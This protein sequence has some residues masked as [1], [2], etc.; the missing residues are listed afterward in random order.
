M[1]ARKVVRRFIVVAAL[2]LCTAQGLAPAAA[3][4]SGGEAGDRSAVRVRKSVR[5]LSSQERT[6]FVAAVLA[7]KAAKSPFDPN[8]NY[9]DQ[10]VA[11][12]LSLYPCGMDHAM[13]S[14]HGGALFL[15]WHRQFLKL[16]EDAL[17]EVSGK[18]ISVPYWDWTDPAS[19][20]AVFANDF[21]GGDGNRAKGF[22]V[23]TG[24]FRRGRW[25][26]KVHPIGIMYQGSATTFLTRHFGSF[27]VHPTLPT[28]DDVSFL[29]G[30]PSYDVEPYDAGSDPN[31]S[32][33]NMLEGFWR[34]AGPIRVTT[35]SASMV[36]T[37]DG[38]MSTVSGEGTHNRVHGWVG[39]VVGVGTQGPKLG[40]M[41]LPTSPNDPVFFLHH[42][43]IDRLWAKWQEKHG[44][45]SYEPRNTANNA[46][47]PFRATPASVADIGALGYRYDDSRGT[48]P[49]VLPKTLG[50]PS[51][52]F[53]DLPR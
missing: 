27:P 22:A 16:F 36:C 2:S 12:H 48:A 25:P 53:C 3:T 32:F 50:V 20:E 42:S 37:P 4:T 18:A 10:F 14:A 43:N 5:S 49:G 6:D 28:R 24:P 23:T 8:L 38:V 30:R 51:P 33:R 21:M 9:Y 40:T 44:T 45:N 7:L 52:I 15:P 47:H 29:M 1:R 41:L 39:G 17:R 11:W 35:G 34:G 31:K 19:T 13:S 46:M 26:L